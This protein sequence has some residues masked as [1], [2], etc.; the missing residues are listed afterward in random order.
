MWN[1][2]MGAKIEFT[3]VCDRQE[4][5]WQFGEIRAAHWWSKVS[6]GDLGVEPRKSVGLVWRVEF[7]SK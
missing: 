2:F 1:L 3:G 4:Q 6:A 5:G 7:V